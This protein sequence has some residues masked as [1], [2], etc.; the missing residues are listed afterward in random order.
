MERRHIGARVAFRCRHGDTLLDMILE[1]GG[2][3]TSDDM[4]QILDSTVP[5]SGVRF[6]D[7]VR[8]NP[9]VVRWVGTTP[10][11]KCVSGRLSI[12]TTVAPDRLLVWATVGQDGPAVRAA[13][14]VE[15]AA[16][17]RL[18]E[19]ATRARELMLSMHE[20]PTT[21]WNEVVRAVARIVTLAERD[22]EVD[23]SEDRPLQ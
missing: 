10:D 22:L 23:D 15:M 7:V 2:A 20:R 9:T 5:M 18:T 11:G 3:L 6:Q 17:G 13:G 4:M 1:N 14:E 19:I 12:Q 8:Q 16:D 21:S